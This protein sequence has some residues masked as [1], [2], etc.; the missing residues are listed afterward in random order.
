M[1]NHDV[2]LA[3]FCSRPPVVKFLCTFVYSTVFVAMLKLYLAQVVQ[4]VACALG[5]NPARVRVVG[6]QRGVNVTSGCLCITIKCHAA[7]PS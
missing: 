4:D 7:F 2:P 3:T 1:S 6:L 5:L